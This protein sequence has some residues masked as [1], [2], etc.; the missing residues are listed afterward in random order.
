MFFRVY[1]R[2]VVSC[3]PKEPRPGG[4]L[5]VTGTFKVCLKRL[6]GLIVRRLGLHRWR[7]RQAD[8]ERI[9]AKTRAAAN[10][11]SFLGHKGGARKE[12]PQRRSDAM[13]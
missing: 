8:H 9:M 1:Y 13:V 3:G 7:A 6:P 5:K 4:A 12:W 11:A 2:L 10:I